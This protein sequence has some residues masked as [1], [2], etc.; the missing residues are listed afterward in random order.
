MVGGLVV[1]M[2]AALVVGVLLGRGIR[3]ADVRDRAD[4]PLTTADQT[5]DAILALA[6]SRR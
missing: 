2:I 4:R 5:A 1:W 6:A 3:L